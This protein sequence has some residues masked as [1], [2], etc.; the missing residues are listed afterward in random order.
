MKTSASAYQLD[1]P[2]LS[3]TNTSRVEGDS[4][5]Y[6]NNHHSSINSPNSFQNNTRPDRLS[7]FYSN[8]VI[9]SSDL[10]S[11]QRNLK[12]LIFKFNHGDSSAN[13]DNS[14]TQNS[15]FNIVTDEL[16]IKTSR[17]PKTRKTFSKK[18]SSKNPFSPMKK[19]KETEDLFNSTL[20]SSTKGFD[21]KAD[22]SYSHRSDTATTLLSM[23]GLNWTSR[24]KLHK[25]E[26]QN[27]RS[28]PS[29]RLI[30][31]QRLESLKNKLLDNEEVNLD[32]YQDLEEWFESLNFKFNQVFFADTCE[33]F[34]YTTE[35]QS[36][37]WRPSSRE[38]GTLNKVMEFIVLYGGI[39]SSQ[40]DDIAI[41]EPRR[42][43]WSVPNCKQTKPNFSRHGHS[44]VA[45]YNRLV[46]FGGEKQ[47]IR[48]IARDILD[49]VWMFDV[50]D[51][52]FTKITTICYNRQIP[53]RKYH[54]ASICGDKMYVYG[55][56]DE[57]S[58]YLSD[59]WE[60]DLSSNY[61]FFLE[62]IITPS[63]TQATG[64]KLKFVMQ[65]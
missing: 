29:K 38:G 59:V 42:S 61:N 35:F 16:T 11:K 63:K 5:L 37:F 47:F 41:L 20:M 27:V 30:F 54:A 4:N 55:G 25:P 44:A 49:E 24:L 58:E 22:G 14:R 6:Y 33:V 32:E 65:S 57:K 64:E 60:L 9:S 43:R 3:N 19:P 48:S 62:I 10:T 28:Y 36:Q 12:N 40:N 31:Q 21:T 53:A 50:R 46:I 26:Q 56:I 17:S 52:Q 2:K 39:C 1:L 15:R 51:Q 18:L 23:T 34:F 13:L 45:H 8:S 7:T